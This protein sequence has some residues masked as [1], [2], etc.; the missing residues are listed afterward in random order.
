MPRRKAT[1]PQASRR[2]NAPDANKALMDIIKN[3]PITIDKDAK[4]TARL[5]AELL[6]ERAALRKRSA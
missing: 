3:A 1:R 5:R 6:K 2:T 4:E